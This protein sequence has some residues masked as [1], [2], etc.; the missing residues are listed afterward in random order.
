MDV[1]K[2]LQEEIEREE[3]ILNTYHTRAKL[4]DSLKCVKQL[5]HLL[6]GKWD[7][8][9]IAMR[10]CLKKTEKYIQKIRKRSK[11]R[12]QRAKERAELLNQIKEV[13]Q[14]ESEEIT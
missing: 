6:Q 8:Q 13:Y 1:E 4:D 11:R 7:W 10:V 14:A 12:F 2:F 9:S 3:Y 5:Q